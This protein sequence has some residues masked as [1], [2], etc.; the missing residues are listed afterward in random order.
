MQMPAVSGRQ[1]VKAEGHGQQL[2]L[3]RCKPLFWEIIP[4]RTVRGWEGRTANKRCVYARLTFTGN[5]GSVPVRASGRWREA[6]FRIVL[7]RGEEAGTFIHSAISQWLKVVPATPRPI[8][9]ACCVDTEH[10]ELG[11][12]CRC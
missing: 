3:P 8:P 12:R 1:M 9:V 5:W 2:L 4:G 7:Q 6:P 11:Q 10:R